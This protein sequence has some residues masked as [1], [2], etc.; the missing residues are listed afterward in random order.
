[1][2]FIV[3][4][5]GSIGRR[6]RDILIAQDH[7]VLIYDIN[8]QYR[9]IREIDWEW[10]DGVLVCTPPASHMHYLKKAI[11]HG[12]HVFV[13]KPLATHEVELPDIPDGIVAMMACNYRFHPKLHQ[14]KHHIKDGLVG[15][16]FSVMCDYGHHIEHWAGPSWRDSYVVRTGAIYDSMWHQLDYAS[17]LMERVPRICVAARYTEMVDDYEMTFAADAFCAWEEQRAS[18]FLHVD[19]KAGARVHSIMV[20]GEKG[21]LFVELDADPE[22]YAL[23]M[24][25]FVRAIEQKFKLVCPVSQGVELLTELVKVDKQRERAIN[26]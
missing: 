24:R 14:L 7:Q 5:G 19:W 11:E 2:R 21:R 15:G 17:Y 26:V 10:P 1:M 4:G 8:P 18:A 23:Q 12:V 20:V 9:D 3:I 25:Y 16:V 22:M 6:H 13:E